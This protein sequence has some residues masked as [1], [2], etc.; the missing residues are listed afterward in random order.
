M[1]SEDN[2]GMETRLRD[3]L[4]IP[5]LSGMWH[6][7]SRQVLRAVCSSM[8]GVMVAIVNVVVVDI[9]NVVV[10]GIVDRSRI[11]T[12][13]ASEIVV[14]SEAVVR[15]NLLSGTGKFVVTFSVGMHGR[16]AL[17][18]VGVVF[19]AETRGEAG[20]GENADRVVELVGAEGPGCCLRGVVGG[21]G[22][23][24]LDGVGHVCG[25]FRKSMDFAFL[26]SLWWFGYPVKEGER[27]GCSALLFASEAGNKGNVLQ[28]LPPRATEVTKCAPPA[29][30][31]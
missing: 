30:T 28:S 19:E 27:W 5:V 9:V 25:L 11:Q 24:V 3:R 13:V 15:H 23:E 6:P 21:G 29:V 20:C 18:G 7:S 8:L 14:A 16:V 12:V 1:L 10:V 17:H 22:G 31:T 4:P 26:G 2:I